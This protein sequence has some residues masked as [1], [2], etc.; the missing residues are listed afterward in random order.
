MK[1]SLTAYFN[2][3]SKAADYVEQEVLGIEDN[4][5]KRVAV[6]TNR[7]ARGAGMEE[8]MVYAMTV[9]ALLHDCALSEYL[10]EEERGRD[11]IDMSRHCIRGEE[12]VCKLPIYPLIRGA[13]LYHHDRADGLGAMHR[14]AED[15]PMSAQLIHIADNADMEFDLSVMDAEK[16]RELCAWIQSGSGTAFS[17]ECVRL[18]TENVDLELMMS[19]TQDRIA[20]TME[21]LIPDRCEEVPLELLREMATVFA[22]IID[23]KSHFTSSH[24]LGVAEKA[25]RL[26]CYYGYPAT[27]CT[28]LYIAG[29][30]HD[31]GKLLIPNPILEK[32]DKLT[33]EEYEEITNHALGTW[34]ILH[35]IRGMEEITRWASLHHEKLDGSGYPFGLTGDQLSRNERMIGCIDVYQALVETRPYKPG[36]SHE[37]A[38]SILRRMGEGGKLDMDIIEDIDRCYR[39]HRTEG[40]VHGKVP[41]DAGPDPVSGQLWRCPVCGYIYWG[42][43]TENSTCPV[44]GQPGSVFERI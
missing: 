26:G 28:E 1:I 8:E 9:A 33:K 29:A 37:T 17:P 40:D 16:F 12:I 24:S 38:M 20:A 39:V 15:T 18:F 4:H 43:S 23:Y 11:E 30:L 7:L 41:E 31:V 5:L 34:D 2:A 35:R 13:V 19:V 10:D 42:D 32:P 3:V 14:R 36:L 6:L 21:N 25:E 44:C 27:V 22:D